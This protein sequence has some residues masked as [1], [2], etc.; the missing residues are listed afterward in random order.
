LLTIL[1]LIINTIVLTILYFVTS[2]NLS[3]WRD[4]LFGGFIAALLFDIAKYGF[5]Y[6]VRYFPSY[7]LIY[8]TLAIIPLFLVWLYISWLIILYGA[9]VTHTSY[10]FYL[11]PK[12]SN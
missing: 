12:N 6:Y 4:A 1:T 5:T 10:Q 3:R 9:M 11:A 2:N 7:E 8:G